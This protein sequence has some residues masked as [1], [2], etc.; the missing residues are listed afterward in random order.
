MAGKAP[1]FYLIFTYL[2]NFQIGQFCFQE[3]KGGN[4]PPYFK[5]LGAFHTHMPHTPPHTCPTHLLFPKH[6][7]ELTQFVCRFHFKHQN[8]FPLTPLASC[9][10]SKSKQHTHTHTH[11]VISCKVRVSLKKS[12]SLFCTFWSIH[13]PLVL[14]LQT[15][16]YVTQHWQIKLMLIKK[17]FFNYTQQSKGQNLLHS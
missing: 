1:T 9:Q 3:K 4:V 17:Y 11:T 6:S 5:H 2:F 10:L 7:D 15:Q 13:I 12:L 16:M 8:F 14:L